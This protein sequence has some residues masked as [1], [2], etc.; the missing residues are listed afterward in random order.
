VI[1]TNA[2]ARALYERL[3]FAA[4]GEAQIGPLRHIFGFRSATMMVRPVAG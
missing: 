1:D 2:R 4:A 3:G